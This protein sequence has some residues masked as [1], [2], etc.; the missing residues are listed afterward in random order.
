[1][2]ALAG[3]AASLLLTWLSPADWWLPLRHLTWPA[4]ALGFFG[5]GLDLRLRRLRPEMTPH[6]PWALAV[7]AVLAWQGALQVPAFCLFLLIAHG[8]QSFRALRAV[9]GLILLLTLF[10]SFVAVVEGLAPQGCF[11]REEAALVW[12]GRRC[13]SRADCERERVA[14]FRCEH[15]GLF[16]T[17]SLR[18]RARFQGALADPD[19]LALV[20][21]LGAPLALF[22]RRWAWIVLPF[23]VAAECFVAG[24]PRS[25]SAMWWLF[26]P[27]LYFSM[28]VPLAAL[29]RTRGRHE[30]EP[31][32]RAAWALLASSL[33]LAA[34]MWR[35]PAQPWAWVFTALTGALH[36]SMRTHDPDFRV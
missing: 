33:V 6:T 9:A 7:A 19:A 32:R 21:A 24:A 8:V 30:A 35:L 5:Y 13:Q 18:G 11:V 20:I 4:L 22:F 34:G 28:K 25:P 23:A 16:D 17:Q 15:I 12:D 14:D 26:T 36:A 3:I 29:R 31:A 27:L 10:V 2:F 1:L